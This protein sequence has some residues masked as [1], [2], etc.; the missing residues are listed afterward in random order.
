MNV[1]NMSLSEDESD[2]ERERRNKYSKIKSIKKEALSPESRYAS[3]VDSSDSSS[4]STL[5]IECHSSNPPEKKQPSPKKRKSDS[6]SVTFSKRLKIR[7]KTGENVHS[8]SPSSSS[9]ETELEKVHYKR[10]SSPVKSPKETTKKKGSD[11]A[12]SFTRVSMPS[13]SAASDS[14]EMHDD[15]E[16]SVSRK[17]LR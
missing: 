5:D 13:A 1:H 3:N 12:S 16:L 14:E 4:D 10:K 17:P 6:T 15:H 11:R 8:M 2:S 7:R 9:G